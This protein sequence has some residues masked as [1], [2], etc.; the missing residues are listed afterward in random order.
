MDGKL[1]R[2][3]NEFVFGIVNSYIAPPNG[4]HNTQI[5]IHNYVSK[6]N[7]YIYTCKHVYKYTYVC[8][9]VILPSLIINVHKQQISSE[10][11]NTLLNDIESDGTTATL[12]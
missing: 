5:C 7:V 4:T 12:H 2:E 6:Y 11:T 1:H 9:N 8:M 10:G 3:G